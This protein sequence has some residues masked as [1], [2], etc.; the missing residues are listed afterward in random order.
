MQNVRPTTIRIFRDLMRTHDMILNKTLNK[1][2]LYKG[3]P[4]TLMLLEKNPGMTQKELA[5]KMKVTKSTMGESLRRME[6]VGFVERIQDKVDTRCNRITITEKG[7]QA[8]R[9]CDKE[10]SA[11]TEAL[12][13]KIHKEE[14]DLVADILKRLYEGICTLEDK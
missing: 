6:K 4:H 7:L 8:L 5:D 10:L 14:E 3:Q 2:D 13:S 12:Y 11:M 1:Y 9:D